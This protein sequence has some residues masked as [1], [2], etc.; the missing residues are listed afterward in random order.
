MKGK[1]EKLVVITP[2]GKEYEIGFLSPCKDGFVL[3]TSQVEGIDTSHLTI[4]SKKWTISSHITPQHQ[5]KREYFAPLTKKEFVGRYQ[6]IMEDQMFFTLPQEQFSQNVVYVTRRFFNLLDS[7]KKAIYQKKTTR[8]EKIHI[9]NLKRAVEKAPKLYKKI[10]K[11]PESFMGMCKAEDLL[12]DK[13]K[14]MGMTDSKII[15]VRY[16]RKLYGIPYSSLTGF[17]FIPSTTP[18][19]D[20]SPLTEIFESFGISQYMQQLE[21]KKFLEKLFKY[22][23][24]YSSAPNMH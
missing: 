13:S 21:R 15:V 8:K 18:Q 23:P 20:K 1:R 17:D 14:F 22:E 10:M 11:S 7:L 4:L 2:S 5:G 19:E 24:D 6:S 9:L 3:G 16:R 12:K